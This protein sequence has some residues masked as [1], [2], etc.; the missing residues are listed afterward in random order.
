MRGRGKNL[1]KLNLKKKREEVPFVSKVSLKLVVYVCVT[2]REERET[3]RT[4]IHKMNPQLEQCH[5]IE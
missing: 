2:K 4:R 1:V 5:G 3:D